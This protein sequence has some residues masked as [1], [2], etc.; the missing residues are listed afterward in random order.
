MNLEPLKQWICDHC[1]EVIDRPEA[2]YLEWLYDETN[3]LYDFRLVHH[4]PAS[5]LRKPGNEGCYK[6]RNQPRC[7]HQHLA[8]FLGPDGLVQLLGFLDISPRDTEE[9]GPEVRST[10]ELSELIRRLHLPHYEEA[11]M[12]WTSAEQ[13]GAFQE[14]ND[15]SPYEQ[16]T[17]K[18]II[19][20]YAPRMPQQAR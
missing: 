18:R 20:K 7:Q 5:P 8:R 19:E 17:L 11:R 4:L 15:T 14:A 10:R 9:H 12:Y 6:Y 3:H 1:H 16:Y 2:G 13:D